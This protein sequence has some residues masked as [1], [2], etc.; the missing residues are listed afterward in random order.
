MIARVLYFLGTMVDVAAG[1]AYVFARACSLREL[2]FHPEFWVFA[3]VSGI[4]VALIGPGVYR[5]YR[6]RGLG[7]LDEIRKSSRTSFDVDV[8]I[9]TL[10]DNPRRNDDEHV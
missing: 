1:Y 3:C 9:A 5:R 6:E 2:M 8:P 7:K 4:L 10:A